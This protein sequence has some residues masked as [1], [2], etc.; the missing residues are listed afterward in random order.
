MNLPLITIQTAIRQVGG[1]VLVNKPRW[2]QFEAVDD[3]FQAN[4]R[5]LLFESD[6]VIVIRQ[7]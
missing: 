7:Q 2:T 5:V 4:A 6:S 3:S 1:T